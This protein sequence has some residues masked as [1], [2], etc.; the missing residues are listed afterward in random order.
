M[1][2]GKRYTK[3]AQ[4]KDD[5]QERVE[6]AIKLP[7][8]TADGELLLPVDAKFPQ[9]DYERL[10][11]AGELGDGEAVAEASREIGRFH[12]TISIQFTTRQHRKSSSR[13]HPTATSRGLEAAIRNLLKVAAGSWLARLPERLFSFGL[14]AG[15]F[16]QLLSTFPG[17]F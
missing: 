2:S 11:T 4:V 7:G 10:L 15:A 13:F 8:P 6:F 14:L 3:N 17:F 12:F 1:P 16:K 9:E 5:S